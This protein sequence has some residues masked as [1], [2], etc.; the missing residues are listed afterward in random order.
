MSR[1][2]QFD[3][4]VL[5]RA[6]KEGF[7]RENLFHMVANSAIITDVRGNRRFHDWVFKVSN[8]VV[9]SMFHLDEHLLSPDEFVVYEPCPACDGEGC[10][11]CDD[12]EVRVVRK[13]SKHRLGPMS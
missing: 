5:D 12:G 11:R 8:G 4:Q 10:E 9:E 13:E 3:A 1:D 6:K 2:L 7:S